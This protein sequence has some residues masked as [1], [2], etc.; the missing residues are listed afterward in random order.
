M[1]LDAGKTLHECFASIRLAQL[2][3]SQGLPDHAWRQG[4]DAFGRDRWQS[5][6]SCIVHAED[7]VS[8]CRA[9]GLETL[10]TSGYT[11]D[12]LDTRRT[13]VNLETSLLYYL[14]RWDPAR[15]PVWVA[16]KD[17]PTALVGVEIPFAM[18]VSI[19]GMAPFLY[20]GRIDGLHLNS[21]GDIIVGENKTASR[22]DDAWRLSFEMSHQVTGYCAVGSVLTNT[23]VSHAHI[24]G[25]SIPLPRIMS[26]GHTV[27]QVRRYPYHIGRWI[28]WMRHTIELY[29]AYE[30]DI[31][32]APK[33]THSCNRYFRPCMFIPFCSGDAE[34]QQ[35]SLE[36]MVHDEWS[37]L[38]N[39]SKVGD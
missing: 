29:R 36:Q 30:G 31:L 20:T 25:L 1:A 35:L 17:D 3:T 16:D 39:D 19:T 9:A 34:E 21:K 38:D 22:L 6:N 8:A 24:T 15:Y 32:T 12:P 14:Q 5:I 18:H 10:S 27:E 7:A 28:E 23:E 33:Y 2:H 4:C 13:Y 37:P 11:D 26:N